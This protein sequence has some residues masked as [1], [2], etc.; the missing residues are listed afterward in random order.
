[1]RRRSA[2]QAALALASAAFLVGHSPY[3]QWYAYRSLRLI[4][5]ASATDVHAC[6]IADA[7]SE[8]MLARHPESNAMSAQARSARDVVQMLRTHQL[9]VA[10]LDLPNAMAAYAG[11]GEFEREG[12][13]SL[14]ILTAFDGYLLVCLEDFPQDKAYAIAEATALL[15][16]S[17]GARVRSGEPSFVAA[18]PFHPGALAFQQANPAQPER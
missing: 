8:Q 17:V 5:V 10:V 2:L 14:G 11:R 16:R 1:M 7:V 18:I 4:V 6:V 3:K 9:P 13:L 12:A 15:P